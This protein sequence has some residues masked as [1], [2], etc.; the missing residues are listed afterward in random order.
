[1]LSTSKIAFFQLEELCHLL[2]QI[3]DNFMTVL[4]EVS[5]Y[6]IN[7]RVDFN[8]TWARVNQN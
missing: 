4:Y 3:A 7:N 2:D 6:V 8:I 1:M 5:K